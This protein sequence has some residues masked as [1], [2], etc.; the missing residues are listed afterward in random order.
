M[1]GIKISELLA[2]DN[3][4]FRTTSNAMIQYCIIHI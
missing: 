2:K 3:L 1:E 4:Y